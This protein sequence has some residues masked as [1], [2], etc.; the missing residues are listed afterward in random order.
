M[1]QARKWYISP[2]LTFLWLGLSH[3]AL[4]TKEKS[5]EIVFYEPRKE[6][7]QVGETASWFMPQSTMGEME[8]NSRKVG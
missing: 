7:K 6:R 2:L 1:G 3:T 5:W 4:V 8:N